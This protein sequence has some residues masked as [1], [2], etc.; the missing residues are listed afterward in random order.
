[1][2]QKLGGAVSGHGRKT[3][4]RSTKQEVTEPERSMERVELAAHSP[5]QHNISLIIRGGGE[6]LKMRE[7]KMQEWKRQ[8]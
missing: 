2:T 1:M 6:A 8:E 7:W 4:E 3:M 5:L